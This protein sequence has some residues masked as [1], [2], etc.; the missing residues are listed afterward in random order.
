MKRQMPAANFYADKYVNLKLYDN[1]SEMP[2]KKK[3]FNIFLE[4]YYGLYR[5]SEFLRIRM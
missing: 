2:K 1:I 4:L 3:I 5:E